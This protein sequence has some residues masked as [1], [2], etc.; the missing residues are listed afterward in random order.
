MFKSNC[1]YTF[2]LL[3]NTQSKTNKFNITQAAETQQEAHVMSKKERKN[4]EHQKT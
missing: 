4:C 3:L 1:D 2:F